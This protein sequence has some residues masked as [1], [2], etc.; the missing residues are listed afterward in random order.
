MTESASIKQL[1]ESAILAPSGDN[2]QPWHFAV[3]G[4]RIRLYNLPEKDT[5]V[6]NH[7]QSASLVAHGAALENLTIAASTQGLRPKFSLFPE[8]AE[9]NLVADINLEPMSGLPDP[10]YAFLEGRAT[11]RKR[12]DR[13]Y[14]LSGEERRQLLSCACEGVDGV[15]RIFEDPREK[16]TLARAISINDRMVFENRG[17]HDFLYDH[18]RWDNEE[19]LRTRDGLDFQT[20]ELSAMD[21]VAFRAFRNWALLRL[22][23]PFGVTRII[24]KTAETLALSS[25]AL[26]AVVIVGNDPAA[27]VN[28]GRL[29]QR[30]WL[31]ATRLGL[32]FQPTAGIAFLIGQVASGAGGAFSPEQ[33]ALL[34]R[35]GEEVGAL[36][37]DPASSAFLLFRIGRSA[38]PSARSLRIPVE[39]VT[40]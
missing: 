16:Q 31:E 30:V 12:Y 19:A 11:N 22:A 3:T 14:Q 25:S 28:A 23:T 27:Y 40:G 37:G 8:P 13:S 29:F 20:L 34:K 26:G 24:G 6:Y 36:V 1:L 32:S 10:L 38:P 15:V 2:C 7:R 33:A 39:V 18:I 5:S 17:L 21:A 9:P 4:A 35:C